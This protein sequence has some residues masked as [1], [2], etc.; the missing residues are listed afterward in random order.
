MVYNVRMDAVYILG[1]G[2][3]SNNDEIRFSV[4]SLQTHMED[5]N[6]VYVIGEKPKRMPGVN[7]IPCEDKHKKKWQN[8]MEKTRRACEIEALS[9]EF[10]LMNDDFFMLAPFVGA[11]FPFYARKNVDGGQN[12]RHHF[13]IHCP[14]R[15]KKDWYQQMPIQPDSPGEYSPRSFYCNFYGAP[16]KFIHDAIFREGVGMPSFDNQSAG[17]KFFTICDSTMC[18][19]GFRE[20]IE[21]LFP[22]RSRYE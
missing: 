3:L 19:S 15:I 21:L 17:K 9:D 6:D 10:L 1:S 22:N 7:H 4:R 8:A 2:S 13:G 5:L 14:I 12:G 16:P 11:E 18:D 20:W